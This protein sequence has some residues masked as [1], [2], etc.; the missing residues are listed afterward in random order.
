MLNNELQLFDKDALLFRLHEALSRSD[1]EVVFVVGAPLTAPHAGEI[2][3]ADVKAVVEL[4]RSEFP[5][6]SRHR[7]RF[8]TSVAESLNPYQAAFDFLSGNA[9][10]DAANRIV[11]QAVAQALVPSG[12][13]DWC[14]AIGK[15]ADDNLKALDN[16]SAIWQLSPGVSALGM[17][18]AKFPGRFGKILVT[19]NFDPLVEVSVRRNGGSA[20]RTSLSVDGSIRQSEAE[21]CQVIHI[22]GYWYGSDT[23]HTT[24]QLLQNR[25]TL[26]NDLLT[27]LQ[28]KIVV[29]IAYGGWP[30]IFTGA[31][32]GIVSNDNLF[33]EILWAFHS[34]QP[35]L[36]EHLRTTLQPGI[37][38]NRVTFYKGID[39]HEF[40]PELLALWEEN[41][42]IDAPEA[43]ETVGLTVGPRGRA[44]LFRLA[45][46][47]CDRP[48]N[49]EVWVGRENELRALETSKAK[50]VII[51]GMGGEG[52]SVLAS[53]YIG[54]LDEQENAYRMWDWRD[55][56]EQSDRIRTQIVE[57]IVRFS[58]G[59]VS[60]DDLT[61]ADDRE[62][63]EVLIDQTRDA[64][65]ILVFDNVDSYI[66]LENRSFIGILDTLVQRISTSESTSRIVL[67]CRPDVQYP[68]SSVITLPMKGISV[69]EAI[70]LFAKRV[71]TVTIPEEDIREA[72]TR[73]KGHAFWLDLLAV[74]VTKVPGT[75][76]R[77]LLN[78]MRRGRDD[79]P[80][81]LS[82]LWDKLAPREQTLL[83]C[84]AEA[85]RPE[86]ANMIEGFV[87]SQLNY[88][89]FSKALR[90]LIALNL[91]VVKPE[92]DA[93]D[94]YDLHPLVRQFVRTKF[95]R[96]E[97]S[98]F[99][100]V[101]INQ[102][103]LIIGK[104]EALLGINMP[105]AMLER[106]SQKAELQ[107]A[108]GL[109]EEAFETLT[110][111]EDAFIGGGHVQEFVRVGRLLFEAIDW[112]TAPTKHSQFDRIIGTM[113][114]ALDQL[115]DTESADG[116]LTRYEGTI[117]QKT[118][119][120]INFC[121][122][123]AYSYWMRGHFEQAI[124]WGQKGVTLKSETNVDTQFDCKYNLAL[125]QRDA[126]HPT[127][128]I[129]CFRNNF[130]VADIITSAAGVPANAP[131]YGNVG[132]CLHLMKR[133]DD[134]LACYRKSLK[135][136]EAE[137]SSSTKSNRAYGRL[138]VGQIFADR[139][140]TETAEAFFMDAIRTLGSSAPLRV[141]ELYVE[142][143][144]VRAG[145]A[146]IMSEAKATR[147]VNNWMRE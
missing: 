28:D 40:F 68:S 55:C 59:R 143:E 106:W 25:P 145:D 44:R 46:L 76:L 58:G 72:H 61:D 79:G 11:K 73:T 45:P 146:L 23:L 14:G 38:R 104:I 56:K 31:L 75:T 111:I 101:V 70:E 35:T 116:M 65:A 124:E 7:E 54:T 10:Q 12:S 138:W 134:A 144:K 129:E 121:D 127:L 69:E 132:R 92:A 4:I 120:Y 87:A 123:R 60:A 53:H 130:D 135:I 27:L 41:P 90:S 105:Y 137:S 50:V 89:K 17:L 24:R 77:K 2:G 117:P 131:M 118:A 142:V 97:R 78:D 52:K 26:K 63:V 36:G 30:D 126:G 108:A 83:R 141:R 93:P 115:G 32:G 43:G 18:I 62:L 91:I 9:G 119:R 136:L 81:I 147:I 6:H 71:P 49:I 1:K 128:A 84:M 95:E 74:Q 39:C 103:D 42:P 47:E 85:V 98:G 100:R 15:L 37:I 113:I 140:D 96:A 57:I 82:S 8:E 94:L 3:V 48:P 109:F 133:F 99:I 67:T 29:V 86:T 139:G 125:A 16:D 5:E 33:P 22:H 112:E 64:K 34:D 19:S 20:W 13:N 51:C 21:G 107:V 110:K 102:Y 80:D 122:V 66:D 88:Q 114:E